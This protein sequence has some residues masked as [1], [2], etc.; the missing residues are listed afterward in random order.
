MILFIIIIINIKNNWQCK[1]GRERLIPHQSKDPSPT[2]PT[3]RMK[4]ENGKTVGDKKG[5]SSHANKKALALLV[6]PA[7][8]T[9]SNTESPTSFRRE[10]D[11]TIKLLRYC[12][13]LQRGGAKV[14]QY[15]PR[16]TRTGKDSSGRV[17]A[18]RRVHRVTPDL[19]QHT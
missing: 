5:A 14:Y 3:H 4:E 19:L 9:P 8:P 6:K 12:E 11:R 15:A 2:I 18:L 7:S 1:A 10:T 13:V 16:L 17:D